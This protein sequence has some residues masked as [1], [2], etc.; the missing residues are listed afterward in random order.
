M[1]L[2]SIETEQSIQSF[3]LVFVPYGKLR[4]E[5]RRTFSYIQETFGSVIQLPEGVAGSK[6]EFCHKLDEK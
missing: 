4:S 6:L 2:C 5:R 3:P 1:I